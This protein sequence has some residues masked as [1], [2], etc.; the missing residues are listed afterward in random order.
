MLLHGRGFSPLSPGPFMTVRK[1]KDVPVSPQVDLSMKI[2]N[3]SLP[4]LHLTSDR[5]TCSPNRSVDAFF[6]PALK[7][8][9]I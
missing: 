4:E 1:F 8:Q 6:P 2:G 9:F 5:W 7:P 3:H